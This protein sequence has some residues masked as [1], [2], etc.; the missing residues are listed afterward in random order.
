MKAS[1]LKKKFRISEST[2]EKHIYKREDS[3]D[4][5]SGDD[6]DERSEK[7]DLESPV[8]PARNARSSSEGE[9]DNPDNEISGS[10]REQESESE[11][12]GNMKKLAKAVESPKKSEVRRSKRARIVPERY[13]PLADHHAAQQGQ[14]TRVRFPSLPRSWSGMVGGGGGGK[15]DKRSRYYSKLGYDSDSSSSSGD[16]LPRNLPSLR[17]GASI[18]QPLNL[19]RPPVVSSKGLISCVDIILCL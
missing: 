6:K 3:S 12:E 11:K 2:G 19:P 5:D 13:N 1:E 8:K 10:E 7:S 17:M 9:S 18:P 4:D 16:D 15:S 14:P